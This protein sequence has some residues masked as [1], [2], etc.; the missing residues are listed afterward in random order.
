MPVASAN[1]T[2]SHARLPETRAYTLHVYS[3]VDLAYRVRSP[4]NRVAL[5]ADYPFHAQR[6]GCAVR[7]Q[8]ASPNPSRTS[9]LQPSRDMLQADA[10]EHWEPLKLLS[11]SMS[12]SGAGESYMVGASIT[13]AVC[14]L[15]R[16][17]GRKL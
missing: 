6:R 15:V 4:T 17:K 9:T 7:K 1:E 5:V 13:Y 16:T 11:E 10:C 12:V 8:L 2:G 3:S 14:R